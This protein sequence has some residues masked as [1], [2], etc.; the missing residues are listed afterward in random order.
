MAKKASTDRERRRE[1]AARGAAR[2]KCDFVRDNGRRCRNFALEGRVRCGRHGG[3]APD[4]NRGEI[5]PGT[6]DGRTSPY[7]R[8]LSQDGAARLAELEADPN[9]FDLRRS[10][11]MSGLLIEQ[12]YVEPTPEQIME[13]ARRLVGPGAAEPTALDIAMAH[14]R[15]LQEQHKLLARHARILYDAQRQSKLGELLAQAAA[16]FLSDLASTFE[17]VSAKYIDDPA[18]HRAF[19]VAVHEHLLATMGRLSKIEG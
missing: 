11:A 12:A 14:T 9:L 5:P 10:A 4:P 15:L 17:R 2:P 3:G 1:R 19:V 13:T 18:R 8:A 16:P 7:L 6:V